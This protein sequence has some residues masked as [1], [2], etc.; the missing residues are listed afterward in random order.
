VCVQIVLCTPPFECV[1][2]VSKLSCIPVVN[3][4]RSAMNPCTNSTL[5]ASAKRHSQKRRRNQFDGVQLGMKQNKNCSHYVLK[6]SEKAIIFPCKMGPWNVYAGC[7]QS[8]NHEHCVDCEMDYM[9]MIFHTEW[10]DD[11][12]NTRLFAGRWMQLQ[13][14]CIESLSQSLKSST[15]PFF[16]YWETASQPS[17]MTL[18]KLTRV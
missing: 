18:L 10:W 12:K 14:W 2:R 7:R 13:L 17:G 9:G 3:S 15:R 8:C 4:S 5:I 11:I 6:G 16:T 1:S